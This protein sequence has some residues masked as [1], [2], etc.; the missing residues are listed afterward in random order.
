MS[1]RTSG[2][3]VPVLNPEILWAGKSSKI[4][5]W[6]TP[7]TSGLLG[8]LIQKSYQRMS[9]LGFVNLLISFAIRS[10]SAL[11]RIEEKTVDCMTISKDADANGSLSADDSSSV[12]LDGSRELAIS[13]RSLRIS[14]PLNWSASAPHRIQSRSPIPVPHPTSKMLSP[15]R[16]EIP[17]AFN[18]RR[19]SSS[20][21]W[22]MKSC[23]ELK[24][25]YFNKTITR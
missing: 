4:L 15:R 16:S 6:E 23:P 19:I 8:L 21:S 7:L 22:E 18:T 13:I 25:L 11:S 20:R 24:K 14:T 5:D 12:T 17:A 1:R 2:D 3:S 10:W 9:P